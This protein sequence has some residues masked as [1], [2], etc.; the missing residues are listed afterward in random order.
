MQA[1][2]QKEIG[3]IKRFTGLCPFIV[4]MVNPDL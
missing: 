3:D 1:V 2:Q 4:T